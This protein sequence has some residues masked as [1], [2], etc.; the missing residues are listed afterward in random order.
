MTNHQTD[1]TTAT[2]ADRAHL[3]LVGGND[4]WH[5]DP[6][7]CPHDDRSD[8]PECV[9]YTGRT[10]RAVFWRARRLAVRLDQVVEQP[11]EANAA[12]VAYSGLLTFLAAR[13]GVGKSTLLRQVAAAL[14]VG[15]DWQTGAPRPAVSTLMISEESPARIASGVGWYDHD[16]TLIHAVRIGDVTD[17]GT[18][19]ALVNL[20]RPGLIVIDPLT[21]L[22]RPDDER[23]YSALR[24]AIADWRPRTPAPIIGVLHAHRERELRADSIG[25]FYGSVGWSSSCDV[26]AEL[27]FAAKAPDDPRRDLVVC[28]AREGAGL[29]RGDVLRLAFDDEAHRYAER[30]ED[31]EPAGQVAAAVRAY[32]EAHPG[33]Q[34][35]TTVAAKLGIRR[36]GG[37]R[38]REFERAW[39]ELR[40][41]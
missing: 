34:R 24:Q 20:L 5:D 16:P 22:I 32:L 38:Y 41:S 33:E 39:A 37:P 28:K 29:A 6:A 13:E 8:C 36:G 15:R 4:G 35:K 12:P 10:E 2:G 26:L 3:Q 25:T 14:S 30:P 17:A 7:T 18:L 1:C 21:D 23:S 9:M 27:R 40:R 31:D 19:Q 11:V